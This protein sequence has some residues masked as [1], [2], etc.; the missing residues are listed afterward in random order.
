MWQ[1]RADGTGTPELLLDDE[2]SFYEGRGSSDGEWMV[3]RTDVPPLGEFDIVGFRP[4]LD[5]AVIPLVANA[6]FQERHP[7]LSPVV[8]APGN[9]FQAGW[10][11][12][13]LAEH[14]LFT[15]DRRHTHHLN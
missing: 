6:E 2:L 5:S 9:D 14:S 10:P 3:F 8:H 7:A 4:D 12:F 15:P 13:D 11:A 1:S